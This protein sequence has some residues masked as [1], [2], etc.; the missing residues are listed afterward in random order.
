MRSCRIP[1]DHAMLKIPKYP[2][3]TELAYLQVKQYILDGSLSE[4]SRLTEELLAS[5]LGISKSPVREA[6]NRL[7]SD[8]LV[9]IEPRRGTYVRKFSLKEACDLYSLRELLE[10]HAVGLAEITPSFLA[11][12]ADSIDRIKRDLDEGNLMAYVEEDIHF[13]RLIAA[14]TANTELCRI[15]ENIS[16]KSILCRSKTYR[17]SAATSRDCHDKIYEAFKAGD[18]EL[19]KQAMRDHILFFRDSFLRSLQATESSNV[20]AEEADFA[21]SSQSN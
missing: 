16:Q 21:V 20:S 19:A 17:L 1:P 6:L 10:V 12:L 11:E 8:G 18:H 7:E 5:Q 2:N 3:L 4:G 13:H 15:L 9:S 14:S